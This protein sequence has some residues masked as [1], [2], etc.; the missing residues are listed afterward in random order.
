M[1]GQKER[2][3]PQKTGAPRKELWKDIHHFSRRK[4]YWAVALILVGLLGFIIP[5]IPGLLL[6]AFAVA[7]LKPGLMA[8]L[9]RRLKH[10]FG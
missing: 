3:L 9:R 8:R 4:Y 6:I 7:L 1:T 5:V 2:N 10:W